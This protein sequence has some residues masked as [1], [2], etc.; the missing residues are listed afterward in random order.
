METNESSEGS[1][2]CSLDVQPSSEGLG[3]TSQPF[4][5]SGGSA[6]EPPTT[7]IKSQSHRMAPR[8]SSSDMD[9]RDC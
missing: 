3:T 4:S 1:R 6:G 8:V 9:T 7:W 2:S 5:S